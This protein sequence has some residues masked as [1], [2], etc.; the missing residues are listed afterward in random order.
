MT[1]AGRKK[2]NRDYELTKI[3]VFYVLSF[4]FERSGTIYSELKSFKAE[5]IK[6]TNSGCFG[7]TIVNFAA[8][9]GH[10]ASKRQQSD[11]IFN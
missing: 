3:V 10:Q 7:T 5:H 8:D 11:E 4:L 2:Y 6:H 9:P 1:G